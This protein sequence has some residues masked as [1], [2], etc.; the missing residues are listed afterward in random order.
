VPSYIY[1]D[2]FTVEWTPYV[3]GD[4]VRYEVYVRAEA[5]SPETWFPTTGAYGSST[6]QTL[7]HMEVTGRTARTNYDTVVRV[8][9]TGGSTYHDP[10]HVST[11]SAN[12]GV[13]VQDGE[14]YV[15]FPLWSKRGDYLMVGA[16][17]TPA[18]DPGVT[19]TG[20]FKSQKAA[21]VGLFEDSLLEVADGHFA[22]AAE[23]DGFAC[24][25]AGHYWMNDDDEIVA[26]ASATKCKL[27][28]CHS[29]NIDWSAWTNDYPVLLDEEDRAIP[30]LF[31]YCKPLRLSDG[32]VLM[33][34]Y[35]SAYNGTRTTE[36]WMR[37]YRTTDGE[38][39]THWGICGHELQWQAS[40]TSGGEH[41]IVKIG[42][43]FP[44]EHLVCIIRPNVAT[45][46]AKPY[47]TQSLDS[48]QTWETPVNSNIGGTWFGR[49][50]WTLEWDGTSIY[51][52]GGRRSTTAYDS[53]NGHYVSKLTPT[54][55]E[56]GL[57]SNLGSGWATAVQVE[58]SASAASTGDFG[59]CDLASI[60]GELW[61]VFYTCVGTAISSGGL[62]NPFIGFKR[63]DP[64]TLTANTLTKYSYETDPYRYLTVLSGDFTIDGTT[65]RASAPTG[66]TTSGLL[67]AVTDGGALKLA[68]TH[69]DRF[70]TDPDTLSAGTDTFEFGV[71]P[72]ETDGPLT[73]NLGVPV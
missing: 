69:A 5:T 15:G 19:F 1:N 73:I 55:A 58:S 56:S 64:T 38:N 47:V 60:A 51:A 50:P 18:H 59:Y 43:T 16:G 66:I 45:E 13:V 28:T 9:T 68:G 70:T 26:A 71:A 61:L 12:E 21:N 20:W 72:L 46:T 36:R 27:R 4:F 6:D 42:G 23:G 7:D 32:S 49:A 54:F 3:G 37:V 41:N 29:P 62:S 31:T 25:E 2:R 22:A 34:V 52:A 33:P 11:P 44:T 67:Q 24:G 63:L 8:V 65:L 30:F 14:Y 53:L 35:S 57:I 10:E 17:A 39:W 48:G 40:S